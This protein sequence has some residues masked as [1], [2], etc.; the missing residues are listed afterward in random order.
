MEQIKRGI[1]ALEYA[2]YAVKNGLLS[3]GA[4]VEYA[5]AS[6]FLSKAN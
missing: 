2:D 4:A 1:D 5:V 6:A 3:E